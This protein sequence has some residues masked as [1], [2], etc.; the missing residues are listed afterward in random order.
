MSGHRLAKAGSG[1]Y[2]PT[3]ENG[4][5]VSSCCAFRIVFRIE[6]Q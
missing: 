1:H 2:R 5:P 4:Q 6:D 3:T